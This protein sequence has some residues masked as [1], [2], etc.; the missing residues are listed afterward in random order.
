MN[1]FADEDAAYQQH[2]QSTSIAKTFKST[3]DGRLPDKIRGVSQMKVFGL[4]A[5]LTMTM[6]SS[7]SSAFEISSPAVGGL[8]HTANAF[9]CT[10]N[11]IDKAT[12][13]YTYAR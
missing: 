10:G 4:L 9:G 7:P 6:L 1:Q 3:N 2:E 12:V 13:T 5:A 11:T 8:K